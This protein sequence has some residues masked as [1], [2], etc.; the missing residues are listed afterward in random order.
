MVEIFDYLII[1]FYTIIFVILMK[2]ANFPRGGR[3]FQIGIKVLL[4]LSILVPEIY[5]LCANDFPD[6]S[7]SSKAEGEERF[8]AFYGYSI[9]VPR[10]AGCN[11]Q[12]SS[13]QKT[14]SDDICFC[15]CGNNFPILLEEEH[16]VMLPS[17]ELL[18]QS[19]SDI[20]LGCSQSPFRPPILT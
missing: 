5:C 17:L 3:F 8:S 20:H 1:F 19:I 6:V 10:S 7:Q 4:C 11:S 16:F 2:S 18:E 14:N 12:P 13:R 9:K 15:G